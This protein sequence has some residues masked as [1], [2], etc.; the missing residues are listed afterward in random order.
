MNRELGPTLDIEI[1][2]YEAA[3]NG[4]LDVVNEALR[5]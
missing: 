3:K 5:Q 1:F 2:A 4:N